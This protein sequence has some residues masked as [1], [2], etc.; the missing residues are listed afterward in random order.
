M[1]EI[2]SIHT[3]YNKR[4]RRY[5]TRKTYLKHQTGRCK[6]S[7]FKYKFVVLQKDGVRTTHY[8]HNLLAKAFIPNPE[9]KSSVY[10]IDGDTTNNSIDNLGWCSRFEFREAT[11]KQ[12]EASRQ[13]LKKYGNYTKYPINQYDLKRKFFTSV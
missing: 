1:G 8:I 12:R 5:H 13:T 7:N 9:N 4:K 2:L 3:T 6:H 11:E 10:H